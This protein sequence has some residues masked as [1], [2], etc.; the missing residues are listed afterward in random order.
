MLR[1]IY[2]LIF[3]ASAAKA[4][5]ISNAVSNQILKFS[6]SSHAA[7]GIENWQT[8]TQLKNA[9]S[10]SLSRK[11]TLA[12][13]GN[14][15][16]FSHPGT[17]KSKIIELDLVKSQI[18]VGMQPCLDE[19]QKYLNNSATRA[20]PNALK[21]VLSTNGNQANTIRDNAFAAYTQALMWYFSGNDLY[22][23]RS[24]AILNAWSALTGFIS[25]TDQDKLLAGWIG[26]VMAPAAEILRL[27]S[28]WQASNISKLQSTHN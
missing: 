27:Y 1:L 5:K 10:S 16:T 18:I 13:F 8:S 17:L 25:V 4:K 11:Q 3:A 28:G 12:S 2:Y 24:I 14:I 9:T 7:S 6:V 21:T 19:Y 26:A 23:K 22:A 20:I 15:S